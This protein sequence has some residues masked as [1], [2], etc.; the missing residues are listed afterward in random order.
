MRAAQSY[1]QQA[2]EGDFHSWGSSTP[3]SPVA[4]G[5]I[6]EAHATPVVPSR[7]RSIALH[8]ARTVPARALKYVEESTLSPQDERTWDL[9]DGWFLRL[10][11][12]ARAPGAT[13]EVDRYSFSA[14]LLHPNLGEFG[15]KRTGAHILWLILDE[16]AAGILAH[17]VWSRLGHPRS[18]P[19]GFRVA[20]HRLN[21]RLVKAGFPGRAIESDGTGRYR[22]TGQP[23][24]RR[25]TIR[26]STS[27]R[28][29]AQDLAAVSLLLTTAQRR[30]HR[31]VVIHGR[32]GIGKSELAAH[33]AHQL[34]G[35][36]AYPGG[37][38]WL[39]AGGRDLLPEWAALAGPAYLD[40]AE[41]REGNVREAAGAA[42]A[43]LERARLPTLLVLDD[44][45]VWSPSEPDPLPRGDHFTLLVTS[46]VRRLGAAQ[47]LQHELGEIDAEAAVALLADVSGRS[48]RQ[49]TGLEALAARFGGHA[50]TLELAGAFL[51]RYP[52]REAGD[53]LKSWEQQDDLL[54]ALAAETRHA[55][56]ISRA[57]AVAVRNLPAD[58]RHALW[59]FG[60][61][62]RAPISGALLAACRL[63]PEA[64]EPLKSL[65]LVRSGHADREL[66]LHEE[67]HSFARRAAAGREREAATK[68]FAGGCMQIATAISDRGPAQW[69]WQT[70]RAHLERLVELVEG[71]GADV[72]HA[73]LFD[74][75]AT[76]LLAEGDWLTAEARFR[77]ALRLETESEARDPIRE[78]EFMSNHAG[79][80]EMLG[81]IP[82]ALEEYEA[83]LQ[84]DLGHR[85]AE[86][87]KLAERM[88]N[89]A[90]ALKEVES[91]L[92]RAEALLRA[93]VDL[94]QKALGSVASGVAERR[95][96]LGL[97]LMMGGRLDE[98]EQELRAALEA[99]Q[100]CYGETAPEV[101]VRLSNLARLL[102]RRGD[103][104]GAVR[105]QRRA[106]G[107]ALRLYG[108]EHFKT[109]IRRS[110]L[111][112]ALMELGD[113]EAA[114]AEGEE[115]L[116]IARLVEPEGS[117]VLRRLEEYWGA[118]DGAHAR[119]RG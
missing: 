70:E 46:R 77:Q 119:H 53:F 41:G 10:H 56:G 34:L 105:E 23:L 52:E 3:S 1:S 17:D 97:V 99:D 36:H 32:C 103:C 24:G 73:L 75:T 107:I 27:F 35:S 85:S 6:I 78:A 92:P 66:V 102:F 104:E 42:L 43:S 63:R 12:Q 57:L 50:L 95:N 61:A 20:V 86:D 5:I 60:Q 96:N 67:V 88:S 113:V 26:T 80:L 87:P 13:S 33:L 106:L 64:I 100:A 7:S 69:I 45:N 74:R 47:F 109:A 81:R 28:G 40:L 30:D 72:D 101:G 38:F 15:V 22:L 111:G 76:G 98:A 14:S 108:E 31:G 94:E 59:V 71:G 8:F 16:P 25:R 93:A 2:P 39:R 112:L 11:R 110:S 58:A 84:S 49:E 83:A 54:E 9:G 29:R 44:L 82:E 116:R 90:M 89:V 18:P 4:L 48:P 19:D 55:D 118:E 79:A 51:G 115:A 37:I 21:K 62:A 91:E 68:A 114:A 65:H 117:L